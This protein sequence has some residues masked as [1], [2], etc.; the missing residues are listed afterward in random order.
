M[1]VA[2]NFYINFDNS[3]Y[4]ENKVMKKL[5]YILKLYYVID[6]TINIRPDQ[7]LNSFIS[8]RG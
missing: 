6:D 2:F 5:K 8:L 3:S 7:G 4:S 1:F